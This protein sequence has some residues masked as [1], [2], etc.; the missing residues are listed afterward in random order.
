MAAKG[1][2]QSWHPGEE[3]RWLERM[4]FRRRPLVLV[5]FIAATVFLAM[6]T[7][8]LRPDASFEKMIPMEHPYIQAMMRHV[9]DL[10]A[11]GT[12]IQ[13]AVENTQGDIFDARYL[14]VLQQVNDAVFYLPGVDRNRM[15]SLWTPN[16]RWTEVTEL[17]FEGG[18]VIDSS[19]DGSAAAMEQLRR[20]ILRSGR[21]RPPGGQ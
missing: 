16:V 4:I 19:Y 11:A 2:L 10:G 20:N 8:K 18:T 14:D 1:S 6:Q 9:A 21:D 15:R 5:L 13:V 3:E 12:T 17:G 7:A